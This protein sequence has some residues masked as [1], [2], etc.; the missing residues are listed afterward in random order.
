[1]IRFSTSVWRAIIA[2]AREPHLDE[3]RFG[4]NFTGE[5][6][7]E[8][9]IILGDEE[10]ARL[11]TKGC[12]QEKDGLLAC[13]LATQAFTALRASLSEQLVSLPE[14]LG[15]LE[16]CKPGVRLAPA[17]TADS[18]EKLAHAPNVICGR[19]KKLMNRMDGV[20]F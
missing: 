3:T 11:S 19:C 1:M 5:S 14:R 6:I 16:V 13:L 4:F 9:K 12:Y 8:D 2:E 20:N 17:S 7:N 10:S 18:L 15:R